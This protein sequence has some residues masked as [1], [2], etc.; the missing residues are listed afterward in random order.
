MTSSRAV[1][2]N[3]GNVNS[4]NNAAAAPASVPSKSEDKAVAKSPQTTTSGT[5]T[6]PAPKSE[7]GEPVPAAEGV[8]AKEVKEEG[9]VKEE[10]ALPDEDGAVAPA[11]LKPSNDGPFISKKRPS[12]NGDGSS[13]SRVKRVK[14]AELATQAT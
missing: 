10:T 2:R 11:P 1:A 12:S 6:K 7:K 9:T 5:T 8:A 4:S 14:R 3:S 13:K